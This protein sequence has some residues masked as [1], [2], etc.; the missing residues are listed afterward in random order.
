MILFC[1]V[2]DGKL[3]ERDLELAQID[4]AVV[5]PRA[6]FRIMCKDGHRYFADAK[7]DV[8]KPKPMVT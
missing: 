4:N 6:I 5:P 1:R 7:G 2:C 3:T 8:V